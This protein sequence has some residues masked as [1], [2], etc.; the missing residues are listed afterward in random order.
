MNRTQ[1]DVTAPLVLQEDVVLV[2]CA[3]LDPKLRGQI[4]FEKGDFVLSHRRRRARSKV[5]DGGT[6]AL[7]ALFREPRTIVSAVIENSR[8]LGADPRARFD[9]LLPPLAAFVEDHVL[10]QA[11][12]AQQDAL[13]PRLDSG[14]RVAGWDVVRCVNFHIDTEVYEVRREDRVA[15]LK[16][17]RTATA[18]VKAMLKNEVAVLQ[19]LDGS[20]VTPPLIESGV[21]ETRPYLLV[22]WIDGV[23]AG[24]AAAQRSNDRASQIALCASI[25]AAYAEMHAR[26][27]L[28]GDIHPRNVI[29]GPRVAL[30]DFSLSRFTR[31][32]RIVLRGGID[33]FYEPEY[34]AGLRAG[35]GMPSSPAGEQYG[36]A[37]LLYFLIAGRHYIEFRY[38]GD[39]MGQ[40][41][42]HEPPLPFAARGLAPWPEVERVLFR[43]LEKDPAR[44]YPSMAEFAAALAAVRDAAAQET[45]A[46]SVSTDAN[47]LL[48]TT[49]RSFARGGDVFQR[50]TIA[51]GCAGAAVGLL[52]IAEARSDPALL[53]LADV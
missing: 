37:A 19:R 50:A 27:V 18:A 7:L 53:A 1:S 11:G 30:I 14:T 12:S 17:A 45:L 49:L 26:G 6:A 52:R 20:G 46:T 48:D 22:D 25:A 16:I 13:R 40:Q 35:T 21:H 32:R 4:S 3:E 5:I 43:A 34:F 41:V 38:D 15:A 9:E 8:T 36:V 23:D 2:P 39:E 28:H 29:A 44:R 42:L 51:E 10:V 33:L 47:A 31:G 24:V